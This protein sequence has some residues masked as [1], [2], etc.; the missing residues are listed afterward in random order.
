MFAPHQDLV[1]S[2]S[3]TMLQS[4]PCTSLEEEE[5]EEEKK[6][7]EEGP[8]WVWAAMTRQGI[9]DTHGCFRLF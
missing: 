8:K 4:G 9:T 6:E 3:T 5:E 2:T 7:E 1:R